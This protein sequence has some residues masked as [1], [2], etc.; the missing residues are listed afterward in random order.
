MN[1]V[2]L[3]G[4]D[5]NLFNTPDLGKDTLL[6]RQFLD[7]ELVL[8]LI[9]TIKQIHAQAPFRHMRTAGG[10]RLSVSMTS[11]GQWGWLSDH[12]GYRY[13]ACDPLTQQPWPAMPDW[14]YALACIAARRAGFADFDPQTCLINCY[15]VGSKLS[16]HQ[17]KDEQQVGAPVVGFSLGIPALFCWGGQTRQKKT[18]QFPLLHGDALIFGGVDRLRYHGILPVP[19]NHHPLLKS[20][21]ISLTFRQLR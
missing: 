20:C 5:S 15:K 7:D 21:R 1:E 14:L 10:G 12:H 3:F 18:I 9:D 13:S 2:S 4:Y 11:C 17:D 16:L 19:M 8:R 6:I